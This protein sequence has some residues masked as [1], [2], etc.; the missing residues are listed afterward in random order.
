MIF[1]EVHWL[2]TKKSPKS[3][4]SGFVFAAIIN[5]NHQRKNVQQR[6]EIF[7]LNRR[8]VYSYVTGFF[9]F[10]VVLGYTLTFEAVIWPKSKDEKNLSNRR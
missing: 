5:T 1:F 4:T 10:N 6:I 9:H 7:L 2:K 3:R 8:K